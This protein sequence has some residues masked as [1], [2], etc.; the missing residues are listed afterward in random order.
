MSLEPEMPPLRRRDS[1]RYVPRVQNSFDCPPSPTR[2]SL[3]HSENG[4][5][6]LLLEAAAVVVVAVAAEAVVVVVVVMVVV[7][8]VVVVVVVVA[9]AV[10]A[11][12]VVVV[13]AVMVVAIVVGLRSHQ[14]LRLFTL[15]VA[16]QTIVCC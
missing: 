6:R 4:A 9:V 16:R 2:G 7:A 15:I 10:V 14:L 13:G 1:S 11:L 12:V 5:K 3:Q 8:V